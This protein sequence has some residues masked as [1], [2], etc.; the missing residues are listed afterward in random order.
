MVGQRAVDEHTKGTIVEMVLLEDR[1][2]KEA[3]LALELLG[4]QTIIGQ[5]WEDAMGHAQAIVIN[6]STRVFEGAADP[7][8][9]GLALGW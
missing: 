2:L 3:P 1:F 9:D 6:P 5:P 8:C 4:H 7:R